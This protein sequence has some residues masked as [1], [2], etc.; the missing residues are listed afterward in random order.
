VESGAQH[1][2]APEYAQAI[3]QIEAA[4]EDYVVEQALTAA[5]ERLGMDAAYITT[6]DSE[7][8]TVDAMVGSPFLG[9]GPGDSIPIDQTYCI[10]MLRGVMPNV[11]PDSRLEPAVR[12]LPAA[13]VIG[14]YI[15]VPVALS[16]G[17][18]HGTLCCTSQV[19]KTD[20]GPDEV[21]FMKVLARIVAARV[22]QA[23]GD[24]ARMTERLRDAPPDG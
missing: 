1:Q 20:L 6:V 10:R 11:V 24:E 22:E 2:V 4:Q 14:A 7:R 12:D 15:G 19:A 5:R 8:Q 21:G 13:R 3:R 16:D 23:Q 18:V 17:R 9:L